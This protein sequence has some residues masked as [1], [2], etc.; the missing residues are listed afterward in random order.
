MNIFEVAKTLESQTEAYY[1]KQSTQQYSDG[2]KGIFA[3]LADEEARHLQM[4]VD[5][6]E[7]LISEGLDNFRD[8]KCMTNALHMVSREHVFGGS[9]VSVYDFALE[10][11]KAGVEVYE[12]LMDEVYDANRIDLLSF[13]RNEEKRHIELLTNLMD[14]AR[15]PE[16]W[17]E[18]P[19][20]SHIGEKY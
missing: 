5:L 2:V 4:V 11:E 17:V 6:E 18:S 7:E 12:K 10:L 20:F 14:M 3:M 19:E 16:E 8:G 1:R 15:K 13:L 9:V